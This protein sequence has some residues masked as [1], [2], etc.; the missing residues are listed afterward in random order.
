MFKSKPEVIF[1]AR[2]LAMDL[3]RRQSGPNTAGSGPLTLAARSRQIAAFTSPFSTR[4]L[5]TL[6]A[7]GLMARFLFSQAGFRMIT[8]QIKLPPGSS[9]AVALGLSIQDVDRKM[10]DILNSSYEYGFNLFS[11]DE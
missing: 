1:R 4:A 7:P 6:A 8:R 3:F 10:I 5:A 9:E 11:E 2:S